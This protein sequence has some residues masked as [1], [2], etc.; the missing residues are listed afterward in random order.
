[1]VKRQK[2]KRVLSEQSILL[3]SHHPFI[4]TLHHTFQSGEFLYLCLEF[5]EG[6]EFFTA[7]QAC[8]GNALTEADA[9]FYAAEVVT[10]L[11][12]LHAHGFIY[13]DLKPENLLLSREGHLL[14]SDF[15]LSARVDAGS[16]W[17]T[18]S[19]VGTEEYIAPEVICG[20]G[21]TMCV[22]WWT[23]G[24]LIYEMI[25]ARTPF[26]ARTRDQTF[27]RI[28][29]DEVTF[30]SVPPTPLGGLSTTGKSLVRRLL[31]KDETLRLGS[32]L[33]GG[34]TD[35]RAH[36]WFTSTPWGELQHLTPPI[37]PGAVYITRRDEHGDRGGDE[38]DLVAYHASSASTK[39]VERPKVHERRRRADDPFAAFESVTLAHPL[40]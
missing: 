39:A 23:L 32:A 24:V 17:R 33:R 28:L 26:K 35:I 6:G 22:D 37:K 8:D 27:D 1:M 7:L 14:L 40:G 30:P 12:Y 31:E 29:T 11:A 3:A 19:F 2:V 18:N 34:A 4:V 38:D 9:R 21:H 25:Y 36:F 20:D 16:D 5:A 13:R 10:A 15:D